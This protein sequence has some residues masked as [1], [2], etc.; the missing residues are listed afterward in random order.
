M[1]CK[2]TATLL[3]FGVFLAV[4]PTLAQT[5]AKGR[6]T[7]TKAGRGAAPSMDPRAMEVL[8]KACDFLK[9]QQQFTYKG[10]VHHDQ[11]YA[12]GKK[13]QLSFELE[14][15]VQRPDKLRI[16]GEGDVLNKLFVYD[17]KTFTLYDK[18][19][20]V[21]ATRTAPADI[22]AALDKAQKEFGLTV[23]LSDLASPLLY[24]H[25]SRS[26]QHALYVGVHKVRGIPCHHLAFDRGREHVQLWIEA[27]DKPL[28]RKVILTQKVEAGS[29]QWSATLTDWNLSPQFQGTPFAFV[30]PK[31]S[32]MIDFAP[33]RTGARQKARPVGQKRRRGQS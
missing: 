17:G 24:E 29:P 26:L 5:P 11:V 32:E 9:T 22:E 13:L 28:I 14:A 4:Q 8:R 1:G 7:S 16:S 18:T 21:Y 12:G 33:P 19:R 23:A 31:G 6:G 25:I 3:I 20:N 30:P 27:G 15:Q 10:E 2:I